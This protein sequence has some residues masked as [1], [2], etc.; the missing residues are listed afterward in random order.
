M[1]LKGMMSLWEYVRFYMGFVGNDES[2][3]SHVPAKKQINL[4]I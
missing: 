4:L 1:H 2:L 3:E